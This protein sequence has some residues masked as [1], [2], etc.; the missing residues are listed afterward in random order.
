MWREVE[1]SDPYL[2][3]TTVLT[4]F[5]YLQERCKTLIKEPLFEKN[6]SGF[7]NM[8]WNTNVYIQV[9]WLIV[10]NYFSN[11]LWRYLVQIQPAKQMTR[12][13]L[14]L[15]LQNLW[16][17]IFS[18]EHIWSS[19]RTQIPKNPV[20][21]VACRSASRQT[22]PKPVISFSLHEN[23]RVKV[24]HTLNNTGIQAQICL[25]QNTSVSNTNSLCPYFQI[26]DQIFCR[27]TTNQS[28]QNSVKAQFFSISSC[29]N[30][31]WTHICKY[32][33][34]LHL[35]DFILFTSAKV[36]RHQRPQNTC[37]KNNAPC[38]LRWCRRILSWTVVLWSEFVSLVLC[39][40]PPL[41]WFMQ[42][43]VTNSFE[44]NPTV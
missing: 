7:L 14:Q 25:P 20:S 38:C 18:P 42:P 35:D 23:L 1:E 8:M 21:D 11:N 28:K 30:S 22:Y 39:I 40:L 4:W 32:T 17:L 3:W 43:L 10:N 6:V 36:I 29:K 41:R 15:L 16:S 2:L 33:D 37:S 26:F 44:F 24:S 9:Y 12:R 34:A 13:K 27:C 5:V 19:S 31:V